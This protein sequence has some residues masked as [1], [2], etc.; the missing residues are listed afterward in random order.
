MLFCGLINGITP[1]ICSLR[2]AL[3]NSVLLN[4]SRVWNFSKHSP[5]C[6]SL[7]AL[8]VN[9]SIALSQSVVSLFLVKFLLNLMSLTCT[10]KCTTCSHERIMGLWEWP[11]LRPRR[12]KECAYVQNIYT[13]TEVLSCVMNTPNSS[14]N[15]RTKIIRIIIS[16]SWP[17]FQTLSS[18]SRKLDG[19]Q[20]AAIN[21]PPPPAPIFISTTVRS[22]PFQRTWTNST[23]SS[24]EN[25]HLYPQ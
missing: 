4:L 16:L 19:L 24:K 1:K 5:C 13:H 11:I 22:W 3:I 21:T 17:V 8:C 9:H 10:T 18:S 20:L 15:R 7:N 14:I 25:H 6:F 2:F 12:Q 23:T